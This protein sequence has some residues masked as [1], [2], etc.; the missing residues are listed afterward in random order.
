MCNYGDAW[1]GSWLS[2]HHFNV[3]GAFDETFAAL[4]D[5]NIGDCGRTIIRV[6]LPGKMSVYVMAKMMLR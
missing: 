1:H 4:I 6:L 3:N 5:E 2:K